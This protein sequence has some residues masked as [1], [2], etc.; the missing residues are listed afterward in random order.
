MRSTWM[1]IRHVY[2]DQCERKMSKALLTML[3]FV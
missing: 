2:T 1:L 3:N